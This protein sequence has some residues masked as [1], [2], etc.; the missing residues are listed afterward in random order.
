MLHFSHSWEPLHTRHSSAYSR[1]SYLNLDSWGGSEYVTYYRHLRAE[2]TSSCQ[3]WGNV[4]KFWYR[5]GKRGNGSVVWWAKSILN[6]LATQ[7]LQSIKVC[8]MHLKLCIN[9]F[10]KLI[11]L[12]TVLVTNAA[13]PMCGSNWEM[14]L[15]L[16]TQSKNLKSMTLQPVLPGE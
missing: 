9:C 5:A 8:R 13:L 15:N 3:R 10:D 4:F 11:F 12:Q 7:T 14:I 2:P 6:Q 16:T 1:W